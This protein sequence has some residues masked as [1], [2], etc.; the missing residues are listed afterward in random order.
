M[1]GHF[2]RL[3]TQLAEREWLTGHRSV[4]DAYLFV[5]MRWAKGKQVDLGGLTHLDAF[6]ARMQTDAGVQTTMKAEGF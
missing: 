1:L 2:E 6:F 4:A 3:N 5:V